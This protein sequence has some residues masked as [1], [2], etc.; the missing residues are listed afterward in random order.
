MIALI[1][2]GETDW[3]LEGRIQ[4]ST[5]IPLNKTGIRQAEACREHFEGADWDVLISSTMIRAKKTAEIINQ[6]LNLD[7]VEMEEFKERSFGDAEGLTHEERNQQFSTGEYPGQESK[8]ALQTRVMAG[9]ASINEQFPNKR[10]LLVAHGAVIHAIL[11]VMSGEDLDFKKT[12]LLNACIS[13]VQF[14]DKKW[15]VHNY[16][17]IDHLATIK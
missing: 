16:N 8:I 10:V 9:I 17:Q 2:H 6:A 4:G 3:N 15:H 7:L 14:I 11:S 13:N 1:R 12:K 5:D